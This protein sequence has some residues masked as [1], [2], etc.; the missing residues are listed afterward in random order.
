MVSFVSKPNSVVLYWDLP[1]TFKKGDSFEV[2]L[3]EK[4]LGTT[5]KCHLELD[6]LNPN[7]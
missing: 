4:S 6:G 2:K 1:E 7:T 5:E 3:G